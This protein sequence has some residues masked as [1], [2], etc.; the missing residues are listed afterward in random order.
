MK[1]LRAQS[2]TVFR[3]TFS[4]PDSGITACA[5]RHNKIIMVQHIKI[6]AVQRNSI[7]IV[8]HNKIIKVRQL[9]GL[10]EAS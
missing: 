2:N 10:D 5:R 3:F 8:L 6:I 9:N 4:I 7:I 1:P